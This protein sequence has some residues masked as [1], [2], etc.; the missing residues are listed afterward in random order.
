[1][2]AIDV[3]RSG[4]AHEDQLRDEDDLDA[5]TALRRTLAVAAEQGGPAAA[6]ELLLAKLDADATNASLLA[7]AA[8]ER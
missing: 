4:T 5:V 7:T 3:V 8:K 1:M 2:P 6:L